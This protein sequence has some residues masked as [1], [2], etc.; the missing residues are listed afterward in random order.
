MSTECLRSVHAIADWRI[1][2]AS[3]ENFIHD[4]P[5]VSACKLCFGCVSARY[6]SQNHSAMPL[7]D[8]EACGSDSGSSVHASNSGDERKTPQYGTDANATEAESND[9]RSDRQKFDGQSDS[10][11]SRFWVIV[12]ITLAQLRSISMQAWCWFVVIDAGKLED[13]KFCWLLS[14]TPLVSVELCLEIV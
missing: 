13:F 2:T 4:C 7:E 1:C 10:D 6:R 12:A 14:F 5:G 11:H 8:L 9:D 3:D